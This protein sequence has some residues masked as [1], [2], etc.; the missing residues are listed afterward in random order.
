M[1]KSKTRTGKPWKPP[2]LM[3]DSN[4]QKKVRGEDHFAVAERLSS[5]IKS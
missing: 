2:P 3:A 4:V 1:M 5:G